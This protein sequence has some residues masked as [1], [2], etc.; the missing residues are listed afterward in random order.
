MMP[1]HGDGEWVVTCSDSLEVRFGYTGAAVIAS[2]YGDIEPSAIPCL[3]AA[4]DLVFAQRP[5]EFLV[6]G[7]GICA[8]G[9]RAL[10]VLVDVA[11]DAARAGI[12]FAVTGL[13]PSHLRVLRQ[14]WPGHDGA[15]FEHA[16][17]EQA[18]PVVEAGRAADPVEDLRAEGD[19]LARAI[20]VRRSVEMAKGILMA[21]HGCTADEAFARL[22]ADAARSGRKVHEA[23]VELIE[24]VRR[25]NGAA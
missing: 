12:P 9:A 1:G 17:P 20:A 8:L 11:A 13:A 23:A 4:F 19:H 14:G 5:T 2:I 16:S 24:Q 25:G 21:R 7:R 15:R 6:D 22:V 3:R 18:M 10:A